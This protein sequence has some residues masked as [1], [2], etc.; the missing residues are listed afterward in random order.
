MSY[1]MLTLLVF[2]E[3]TGHGKVK[4]LGQ[5]RPTTERGNAE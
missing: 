5:H 1:S 3:G 4:G 2:L